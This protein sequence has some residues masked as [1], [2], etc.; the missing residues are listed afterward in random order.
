MTGLE[1]MFV[2]LD[3]RARNRAERFA[4]Y[5]QPGEAVDAWSSR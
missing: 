5:Q 2:S 4:D 1:Q 3:G